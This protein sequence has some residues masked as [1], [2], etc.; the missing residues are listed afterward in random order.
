MTSHR[1]AGPLPPAAPNSRGVIEQAKGVIAQRLGPDMAAVIE[2]L[3]HHGRTNNLR[4]ADVARHLTLGQLD[5]SSTRPRTPSRP[6]G[7]H[8]AKRS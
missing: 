7:D 5:L 8:W 1:D 6:G 4:L 3:R 2:Q